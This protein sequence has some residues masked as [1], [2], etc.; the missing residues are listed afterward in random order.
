MS[1]V[2]IQAKPTNQ[3]IFFIEWLLGRAQRPKKIP[4]ALAKEQV[5]P[6]KQ[7]RS[8]ATL[9][10]ATTWWGPGDVIQILKGGNYKVSS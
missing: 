3:D 10:T 1:A 4:K 6:L 2:T 7:D 8:N 5:F 9:H